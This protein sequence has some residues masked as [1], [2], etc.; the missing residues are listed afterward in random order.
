M[1]QALLK[2]FFFFFAY[3]FDS[4]LKVKCMSLLLFRSIF[5]KALNFMFVNFDTSKA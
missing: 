4:I 5:I 1:M 2:N 3:L